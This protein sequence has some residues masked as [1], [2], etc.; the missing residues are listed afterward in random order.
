[1]SY[2]KYS[3]REGRDGKVEKYLKCKVCGYIGEEGGIKKVCPAC[4]APITALESYEYKI[5]A[6]RVKL[7]G[8]HIHPIMVHFPESLAFLSFV[9]ILIA[10]FTNG[11]V[12]ADFT[13]T[14]RIISVVLPISVLIAMGSGLLDSKIRFKSKPGPFFNKKIMLGIVFL[15]ASL[16]TAIL[17]RQVNM[18]ALIKA[19]VVILSLVSLAC[20]AILGKIGGT[21]LDAKLNDH[22]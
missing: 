7:L 8:A 13:V 12:S 18:D 20:S 1:M 10:F 2:L 3:C 9:F 14:E 17:L 19:F 21:L 16:V 6:A 4:G 22:R 11:G 5:S 15:A